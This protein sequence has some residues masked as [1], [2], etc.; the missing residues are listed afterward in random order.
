[1][2]LLC[3]RAW[4]LTARNGGARRGQFVVVV[5]L[6]ATAGIAGSLVTLA[7][8]QWNYTARARRGRLGTLRVFHSNSTLCGGFMGAQGA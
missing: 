4:R 8:V 2:A 7:V 5:F 6:L 3:G 1:M